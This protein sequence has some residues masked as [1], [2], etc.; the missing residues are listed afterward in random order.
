MIVLSLSVVK[1]A[2][3]GQT[4]LN[5][6]RL[7]EGHQNILAVPHDNNETVRY[8]RCAR[9]VLPQKNSPGLKAGATCK[10]MKRATTHN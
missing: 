5:L 10:N 9:E 6:G 7:G 3:S 8:I 2:L 4:T 1:T